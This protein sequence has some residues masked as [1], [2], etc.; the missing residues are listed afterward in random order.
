M[1][2]VFFTDFILLRYFWKQTKAS[3]YSPLSE[4]DFSVISLTFV[5]PTHSNPK[6]ELIY[7]LAFH[8]LSIFF[9]ACIKLDRKALTYL[10]LSPT[11]SNPGIEVTYCPPFLLFI[12]IFFNVCKKL[13]SRALIYSSFIFYNDWR[14]FFSVPRNINYF[15]NFRL[16]CFNIFL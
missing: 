3:V 8:L 13:E 16:F 4:C 14:H 2:Y 15:F 5:T 7:S 6:T 10:F 1:L 12:F 11:Y 9:N